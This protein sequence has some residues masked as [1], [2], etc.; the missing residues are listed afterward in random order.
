MSRIGKQAIKIPTEVDLEITSDKVVVKGPKGDLNLDLRKEIK[1]KKEDSQL[2]IERKENSKLVRSL[3][4]LTRTLIANMIEGVTKGF[5][6]NLE[7]TGVGYRASLEG[8]DLVLK[9]GFSHPVRVKP[10]KGIKFTVA[11]NKIEVIG[12]DK[13]KV[14]D[15]AAK[16]RKIRPPDAYK[17]KGIR[18]QGEKVKIKPGKAAKTIG[19]GG[20]G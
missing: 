6:K 10:H 5:T 8:E 11:K 12:I 4:G 2:L 19:L 16:I 9:V 1:V 17:G 13:Q 15:M 3:H 14:G 7:L 20:Q 18:Y